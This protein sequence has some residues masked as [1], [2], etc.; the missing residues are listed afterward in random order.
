MPP[1]PASHPVLPTD[2]VVLRPREP[3]QP[4]DSVESGGITPA[5][6]LHALRRT[7]FLSI[8]LAVAV[9][10]LVYVWAEARITP[11]YTVRT[12]V[13]VRP[14]SGLVLDALGA[15]DTATFQRTQLAEVRGRSVRQA[16]VRELEP[17]N[18]EAL[19]TKPDPVAWL[20]KEI[21]PDFTIAPHT[22][23]I[24]M[25]GSDSDETKLLLDTVRDVYLRGYLEKDVG[26]RKAKLDGYKARAADQEAAVR[27]LNQTLSARLAALGFSDVVAA[28]ER[29]LYLSNKVHTLQDELELGRLD[30]GAEGGATGPQGAKQIDPVALEKATD[31]AADRDPM[32]LNC[33]AKIKELESLVEDRKRQKNYESDPQYKLH[34]RQLEAERQSQEL[35]RATLRD[36]MSE[37]LRDEAG[38]R[39]LAPDAPRPRTVFQLKL[40]EAELKRKQEELAACVKCLEE[41]EPIRSELAS[42]DDLLKLTQGRIRALELELKTPTDAHVIEDAVIVDSITVSARKLKLAGIPTAA[43]F[44]GIVLF[45]AW[46][47]LRRG[48]VNG[49][50]DL[51]ATK[52]RVLGTLPAVRT[53]VLPAF[54][55]PAQE[56]A[57]RDYL[58]LTD[59]IEMT[60]A[61]IAPTLASVR[62]YTLMVTSGVA[63]E[64]KTVLAAHLA[65]RFARAGLRTL[66]I[67]TDVRRPRVAELLGLPPGHGFGDW[68]TGR[69]S[70]TKIVVRG[71]VPGL[72]VVSAGGADAQA[73]VEQLDRRLPE[74]LAAA[75][76]QFDVV[77]LDTAPVLCTPEALALCRHADGVVLSVM[78]D[79]TR[80]SDVEASTERLA[81]AGARLLGAVVTGSDETPRQNY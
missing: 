2:A 15:P 58:K 61:V 30:L 4:E 9:A 72:F 21:N 27:A 28:R 22:L 56:Q 33:R 29:R 5:Q 19:R 66:L 40:I 12:L 75:K 47:D 34:V 51:G 8:P 77:I 78:R 31:R 54:A 53:T 74:L 16:V 49:G 50:S 68:V 17:R 46:L 67:D 23:R 18:L 69:V 1:V 48:R 64:G 76:L 80:V 71:P 45:V 7:W 11:L 65:A 13:H 44:F 6:V 3:E 32:T 36:E 79:L 25:K 39:L 59:A 57:R 24:V 43:A 52:V 37:R 73:V 55:P 14:P 70:K 10:A 63:G 20:E 62:G 38:P 41:I 60:R 35:R 42:Q 26:Q 81:S